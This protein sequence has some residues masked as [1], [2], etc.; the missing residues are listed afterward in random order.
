MGFLRLDPMMIKLIITVLLASFIPAKGVFV[1]IFEYL[2]TAAIALLFFMHGAKL[3]REKIIAGSSHWRLH[4]WIM[5]STFVIFPIIGLLIV[6]WHPVNVSPE[7]YTGFIYLCILP[8]TVQ[9]SIAFTSMAGGNVAAAVCAASASSLLGVFVSPLLVNLVM[10]VHSEMPGNGLEQIGKIM[11]QLLVPFVLGHLSRRWIGAWV[12]KHRSLIGK[13]DQTSIL[14]V[15]YSAF[16]E[17]VV[18]GIWHRVGVDTLL[19]ILVGSV[20]VLFIALAINLTASRLFGFSR[21]DEIVVLFCGSKKSLA[22]GVPMANILFPASSVG[23]IVL[24]LMIFHQVQLMVCSFIAQRYK[25]GNEKRLAQQ[26]VEAQ[27]S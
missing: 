2:T 22:N 18:N 10:N 3:S 12:E 4:L 16:S 25:A 7:I 17:A 8:A 15:V 9:S 20:L 5:C 24:P 6:W 26:Q 23:I 19:W 21:A 11:L 1:D 27:K 13:T 14:L